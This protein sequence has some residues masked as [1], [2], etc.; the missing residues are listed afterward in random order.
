MFILGRFLRNTKATITYPFWL[1]LGKP[2]PDN[3]VYKKRRVRSIGALFSCETFIETGTFYGQM[4]NA[5][6]DH[7]YKVLSV[8]L[9]E[10]LYHFNKSSISEYPHVRIYLGDSSSRLQ[11][12][13]H[14]AGGR[15]LFWLDAHYSGEGTACG[16][17][18]S[19]IL[20][21]LDLIGGHPRNDHCILI[22]DARLFTG[23]EGYPTLEETKAR[24]LE[25]NPNYYISVDHDCIVAL[26]GK[27]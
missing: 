25:I 15:I 26:P 22:D 8:E 5:M 13:L 1:L 21:E 18:V 17:Q 6:K 7:F 10:A 14:D 4:T 2:A 23:A 27:R 12:M 16:D 24:L 3:H 11:D 19:P 9:F 20:K